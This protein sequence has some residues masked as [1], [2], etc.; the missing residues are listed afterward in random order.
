VTD[1][2]AELVLK[3][4]RTDVVAHIVSNGWPILGI[5]AHT[6][7]LERET[8]DAVQKQLAAYGL[9]CTRMGNFTITIGEADQKTLKDYLRDATYTKLAGGFQQYGAGEAL[10]GIGEGAAKGE[11]GAESPALLGI[12]VGL[13]N[14]FGG[15]GARAA[16]APAPVA[17]G[18]TC[19]QCGAANVAGARFCSACGTM[20]ATSHHCTACGVAVPAGAKFCPGCGANV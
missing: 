2:A 1:W 8:L 4:L 11:A 7:D 20:L 13:A 3:V 5:A 19:A 12:G 15:M 14:L 9:Q 6:D 17:G 10:R 18:L 16:V